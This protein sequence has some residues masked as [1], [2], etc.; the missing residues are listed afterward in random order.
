VLQDKD[1][2]TRF[3]GHRKVENIQRRSRYA[4]LI[5]GMDRYNRGRYDLYLHCT[6]A[7]MT[8]KCGRVIGAVCAVL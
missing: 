6:L 5:G 4:D 2:K 7:V 3:A 8:T 1:L